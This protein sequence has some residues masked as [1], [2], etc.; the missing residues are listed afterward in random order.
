MAASPPWQ[1][2]GEP[3]VVEQVVH[4]EH[5]GAS[6]EGTLY[7]PAHGDHLPAIVVLHAAQVPTR[8]YALYRHLS[9][10]LPALGFAVLVFDRRGSGAST[11]TLEGTDYEQLADDGIAGLHAIAKNPLID[12]HHIGFWGLSQGGWL[13]VLAASRT[14]DAAFAISVSAPTVTAGRQMEFAVDNLLTIHGYGAAAID[15][16]RDTRR[17]WQAY[18]RGSNSRDDAIKALAGAERQPWFGDTF[19]STAEDLTVDPKTSSW[20]KEMDLDPMQ[21]VKGT[22]VPLLFIYGGADPWVPV[23]DSVRSLQ[24]LMQSRH[25]IEV[26]V[27]ADVDHTMTINPH[28]TMSFDKAWMLSQHP[29]SPAYFFILGNW[30]SKHAQT[31]QQ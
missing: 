12:P 21:A 23:E 14:H 3:V 26:H 1:V 4:F 11:G 22:N 24:S 31:Q 9:H 16:A 27:I 29:E 30:L 17:R 15:Q 25:D 7:S 10:D 18:L 20:R 8:D 28:E 6:L 19:M 13:A 5:A 2:K